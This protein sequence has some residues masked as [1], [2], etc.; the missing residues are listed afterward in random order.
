MGGG[1]HHRAATH[2][3]PSRGWIYLLPYFTTLVVNTNNARR[4]IGV[5]LPSATARGTGEEGI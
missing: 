3:D 5:C 1:Y 2:S 4:N